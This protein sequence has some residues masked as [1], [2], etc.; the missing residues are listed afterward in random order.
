MNNKVTLLNYMAIFFTILFSVLQISF[1]VDISI[2]AFLLSVIYTGAVLFVSLVLVKKQSSLS[3][4][5]AMSKLYE[6]APFVYLISFV[7]RRAGDGD[8]SY[9]YDV[10]CVLLWLIILVLVIFIRYQLHEKRV[11]DLNP[12]FAE[13][14]A[15]ISHVKKPMVLRVI[16]EIISWVDALV[17]A[18]F[19]VALVNIF[20]FQLYEIPSESMVPE[21]LIKDRVA[22]IKL[23][24]APKFPLTD[25]GIPRIR[26]YK[27][28]DI[29]VFSN[30][31]YTQDRK[32]QLQKLTSQ[33][34][35]MFTIMQVNLNVDEYGQQKADPLV[36]RV[37]GVSG[38]QL[39]MVDGILYGRTKE[40]NAFKRIGE[41]QKWAEWNLAGLPAAT[42]EKVVS[43]R[44]S[45]DEYSLMLDIEQTRRDLDIDLLAKD[46]VDLVQKFAHAK[47]RITG[48][49]DTSLLS[50]SVKNIH[51]PELFSGSDL[52]IY[53]FFNSFDSITRKLLSVEGGESWFAAFMTDWIFNTD[54]TESRD[55]YTEAMFRM[56]LMAKRIFG[57][58]AVEY[59]EATAN[60]VGF[61]NNRTLQTELE[62]AQNIV[63]YIVSFNDLRNMPLFPTNTAGGDPQYIPNKSYFLMGDNRFNSLDMR[64]SYKYTMRAISD[65]DYYSLRYNSNMEPQYVDDSLIL[66]TTS[67]RIFPFTR[68]GVPGLTAEKSN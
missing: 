17:W 50:G 35:Y 11:F 57:R 25:I 53:N 30:P 3:G 15:H 59:A 37:C 14:Y 1:K 9:A 23:A 60:N 5:R 55:Y 6:Y 49:A 61:F 56:N 36:K 52:Y 51:A 12:V 18:V 43:I 26:D 28:G 4:L 58:L 2:I 40:T 54:K 7:L 21:F 29:V 8:T 20:V 13:K 47:K 62:N 38:E 24:D 65:I 10:I 46:C 45:H 63:W 39:V 66:G 27:R 41:D 68:F 42:R 34:V 19:A 32:S 48:S 22:V 16:K 67:L 44:M 33:L 64:H 31:H